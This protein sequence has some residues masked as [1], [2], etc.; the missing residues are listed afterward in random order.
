MKYYII[1]CDFYNMA[2]NVC[3]I[4]AK[5]KEEAKEIMLKLWIYKEKYEDLYNFN[6]VE[7]EDDI[8]IT[9]EMMDVRVSDEKYKECNRRSFLGD[10]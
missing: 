6:I 4:K 5:N 2:T 9:K 1:T 10:F 3:Y 8:F 7:L